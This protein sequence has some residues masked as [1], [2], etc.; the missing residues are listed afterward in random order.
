M[1]VPRRSERRDRVPPW[2]PRVRR[3]TRRITISSRSWTRKR[4]PTHRSPR[5]LRTKK[6]DWDRT[7]TRNR[8]RMS[9]RIPARGTTGLRRKHPHRRRSPP[10]N[11][12]SSRPRNERS[13]IAGRG[14][15]C[16][17][18]CFHKGSSATGH[19]LGT[20]ALSWRESCTLNCGMC[21]VSCY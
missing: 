13:S 5:G 11:T 15:I 10:T 12:A 17:R 19:C 18:L 21:L 7:G 3:S 2:N 8:V 1:N 4:R 14:A 6:S 20:F 16:R 9:T